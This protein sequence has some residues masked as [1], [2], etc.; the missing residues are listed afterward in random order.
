MAAEAL[1]A[2]IMKSI[3]GST[4]SDQNL[5]GSIAS[6]FGFAQGGVMTSAGPLALKRYAGGGV[7]NS[8]Q[9]ALFGEGATPEAFVPLP[10]GRNI[11]VKMQSSAAQSIRIVN[12][13][14]VSVV[15]DYLGSADGEKI[16]MNAVRRNSSALRQIVAA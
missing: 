3:F 9:L 14:D 4:G 11:P 8:P 5:L 6:I 10:D 12:A 1:A 16:I 15:G 13:F 7:A 2:D